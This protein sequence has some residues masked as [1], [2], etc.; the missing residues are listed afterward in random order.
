L[1]LK[2]ILPFEKNVRLKY[3]EEE[4]EVLKQSIQDRSDIGNIDVYHIIK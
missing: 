2:E 3:D 4:M 1:K